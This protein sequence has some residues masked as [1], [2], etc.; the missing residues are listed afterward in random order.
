[1]RWRIDWNKG[2]R[3]VTFEFGPRESDLWTLGDWVVHTTPGLKEY[4]GWTRTDAI[5]ALTKRGLIPR[6]VDHSAVPATRTYHRKMQAVCNA[7]V[8][9]L[10]KRT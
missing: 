1:M 8:Q 3:A 5:T 9:L 4:L 10:E 7:L 2:N 6:F